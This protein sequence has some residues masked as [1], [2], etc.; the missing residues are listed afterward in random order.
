MNLKSLKLFL[1][2][3]ITIAL[4]SDDIIEIGISNVKKLGNNEYLIDIYAKNNIPIA[5]IQFDILGEPFTDQKNGKWDTNEPF[6]DVNSNSSWDEG[7]P[8]TDRLNN[9]WDFGEPYKD[10]NKNKKYDHELFKILEVSGGRAEASGLDFH[11]GKNKGVVL[12][13]SMKGDLIKE[14][15][16]GDNSLFSIKVRKNINTPC[17]FNVQTII[18]GQKGVKIPSSFISKLIK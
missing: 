1:S 7:E 12:A 10:I 6:R 3:F 8:F 2:F 18:A 16:S 11:L 13:F 17:E 4:S 14:V 15:R 5:G 9:Q